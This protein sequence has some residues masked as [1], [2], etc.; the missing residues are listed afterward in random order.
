MARKKFLCDRRGI[1]W[2]SKE[3]WLMASV[4]VAVALMIAIAAG[5]RFARK[6]MAPVCG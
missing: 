1:P 5:P 2:S 4:Y 3:A 6:P